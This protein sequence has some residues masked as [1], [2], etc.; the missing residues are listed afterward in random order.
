MMPFE[1][2][3][4]PETASTSA[5]CSA[6]IAATT[7]ASALEKKD[8]VSEWDRISTA[9]MVFSRIVTD[10]VTVPPNPVPEP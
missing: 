8:G 5:F 9:V 2:K 7:W 10:T 6:R 3:V 1:L 4:A